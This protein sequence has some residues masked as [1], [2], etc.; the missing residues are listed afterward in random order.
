MYESG[1]I[2]SVDITDVTIFAELNYRTRGSE[3][4]YLTTQNSTGTTGAFGSKP[5]SVIILTIV[6]TSLSPII[7][8][9]ILFFSLL[10]VSMWVVNYLNPFSIF[11]K[12]VMTNSESQENLSFSAETKDTA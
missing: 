9:Y 1:S 2:F 4:K 5:M 11:F 12:T 8:W 7:I 6:L 3:G 10:L